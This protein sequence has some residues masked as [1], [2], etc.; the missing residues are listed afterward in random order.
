ML[1]SLLLVTLLA[2]QTTSAD[3]PDSRAVE[4][5]SEV[6]SS[7]A[8]TERETT[9]SV[10]SRAADHD[11]DNPA[12]PDSDNTVEHVIRTPRATFPDGTREAYWLEQ[13]V[14]EQIRAGFLDLNIRS[15]V[16]QEVHA[17]RLSVETAIEQ[18]SRALDVMVY[19]LVGI[20]V[21]VAG[22]L[23]T[24]LYAAVRR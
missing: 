16:A 13:A 14:R 3:T 7:E 20:A 18:A 1:P 12:T 24:G 4:A 9:G 11:S 5:G 10:E 8:T 6:N 2:A 21:G 22:T 19:L 23:L 17:A 15:V